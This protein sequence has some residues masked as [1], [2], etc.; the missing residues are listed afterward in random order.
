MAAPWSPQPE[1]SLSLQ[2]EIVF[3]CGL[4]AGAASGVVGAESNVPCD[5]L[6]LREP[7]PAAVRARCST[8]SGG[9]AGCGLRTAFI[10]GRLNFLVETFRSPEDCP[11]CVL[12]A[13][14]AL[15]LCCVPPSPMHATRCEPGRTEF[16]KAM[17]CIANVSPH[18]VESGFSV[19]I[20]LVLEGT[21]TIRDTALL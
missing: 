11:R 3:F 17:P 2:P 16:V 8:T 15:L 1:V 6:P 19:S 12:H 7:E 5:K 20:K 14:D 21:A 13:T 10:R 9:T 18:V 4:R